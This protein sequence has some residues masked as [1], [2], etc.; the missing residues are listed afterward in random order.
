MTTRMLNNI[1]YFQLLSK[2]LSPGTV[3][4]R[5]S[6]NLLRQCRFFSQ[7][8]TEPS[9]DTN[10]PVNTLQS[11]GEDDK[12]YKRLELELRGV[13]PAVLN[14]FSTFAATAAK[15]LNIEVGRW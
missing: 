12:L 5:C 14:S 2:F 3:P 7:T 15:H 4:I 6:E 10:R 13:D 11:E 1:F 8:T 9:N